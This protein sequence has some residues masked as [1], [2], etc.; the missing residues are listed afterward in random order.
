MI[1]LS[2]NLWLLSFIGENSIKNSIDTAVGAHPDTKRPYPDIE[3]RIRILRWSIRIMTRMCTCRRAFSGSRPWW[4]ITSAVRFNTGLTH[5]GVFEST[6]VPLGAFFRRWTC[7]PFSPWPC[8][9]LPPIDIAIDIEMLCEFR[10]THQAWSWALIGYRNKCF[11][12]IDF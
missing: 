6:T 11:R 10:F 3:G 7:R 9:N 1:C 4:P 2:G 8:W 12:P 5:A